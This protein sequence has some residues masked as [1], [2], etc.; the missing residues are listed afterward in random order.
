MYELIYNKIYIQNGCDPYH[1]DSTRKN[2]IF[3]SKK[4]ARKEVVDLF[5]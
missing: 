4:F 5:S 1:L 3:F 2:A